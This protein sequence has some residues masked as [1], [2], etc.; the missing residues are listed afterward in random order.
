MC[1]NKHIVVVNMSNMFT[2]ATK[3]KP[4]TNGNQTTMKRADKI[5]RMQRAG[6]HVRY[7]SNTEKRICATRKGVEHR[8]SVNKVH[9]LVFGY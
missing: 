5:E 9:Q 8:G 7:T 1:K 3:T 4:N 6:W 2:F